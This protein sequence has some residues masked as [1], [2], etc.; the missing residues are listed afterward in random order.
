[1]NPHLAPAASLPTPGIRRLGRMNWR[2]FL[3]LYLKEVRRFMKVATQTILAP[4]VTTLLFLAIFVLAIGRSVDRMGGVPFME[5]LA[6]GL[7]M[8]T[9]VQNSFANTSSSILIA[10][11]Q[12]N[13]V[14]VL[15]PPL[16]AGELTAGFALGG[17]TRGLL[18]GF[19]TWGAM[20]LIVPINMHAP[21]FVLFHAVAASLML[22]LLGMLGAIWA[23]KFDYLA[24][25][26]NF[27]ITP[28][29][30]LSGTFYSIERLPAALKFVAHLNPFFYM[31]DGFRYGFI[32]HA[33]S[34]LA[35]GI[36]V[37]VAANAGLWILIHR[38]FAIGYR[39]KA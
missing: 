34:S 15:M 33:D 1:M 35:A 7:I 27:V 9:M 31:I 32:G 19:T 37:L 39:L 28:L 12:G 4:L 14:D 30:F 18:V 24:A 17:L 29:A 38:L 8:M 36:A 23:E 5:F 21:L 13:I 25:V 20:T 22:S 16:S 2:G 3:T 26:T 10:K 6:P 11:I